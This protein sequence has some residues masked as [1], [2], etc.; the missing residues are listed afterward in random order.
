MVLT[1]CKG[2]N[3]AIKQKQQTKPKQKQKTGGTKNE[4][5]KQ[6]IIQEGL[7]TR[8]TALRNRHHRN[9]RISYGIQL[10]KDS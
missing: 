7:H 3:E 9:P 6:D 10:L 8:R 5:G 1:S 2:N 4:K